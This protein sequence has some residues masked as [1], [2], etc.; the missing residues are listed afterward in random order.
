MA[1]ASKTS[2]RARVST[3]SSNTAQGV[4]IAT[5]LIP[6]GQG[7]NAYVRDAATGKNPNLRTTSQAFVDA[8]AANSA[9]GHAKRIRAELE[10]FASAYPTHGWD[11]TLARLEAAGALGEIA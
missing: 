3:S 11:A 9:A 7:A 8:I 1:G 5:F 10:S 6:A 4:G 2:S